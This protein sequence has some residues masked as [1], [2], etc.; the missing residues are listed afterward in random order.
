MKAFA[1]AVFV[2]ALLAASWSPA[3][4]LVVQLGDQDFPD[5]TITALFDLASA[6]EPVPFD[7]FKGDDNAINFSESWTFNF[8]PGLYTSGSIT[9]GI[10]D[11]DSASPGGQLAAFGFDGNDLTA[12]LDLLFESSGGAQLEVNVYTVGLPPA[13]LADLADGSATFALTLKGITLSSLG[14]VLP[15]NGAGLDFARL[16]LVEGT[17]VPAPSAVSCLLAGLVLVAMR[18]RHRHQRAG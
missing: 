2:A 7:G 5:G 3:L 18:R 10:F 12:A 14:L 6:G 4:A 15:N 13:T 17:R 1:L 11:H 9:I 16:D 8:A